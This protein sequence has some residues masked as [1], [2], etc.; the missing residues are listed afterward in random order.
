MTVPDASIFSHE[1]RRASTL[2]DVLNRTLLALKK[3]ARGIPVD[4]D[5]ADQQQLPLIASAVLSSLVDHLAGPPTQVPHVEREAFQ[6]PVELIARLRA[7]RGGD[8]AYFVDDLRRASTAL[9]SGQVDD[10][11]L[12]TLEA[13]AAAA[14]VEASRV[15][16][17][18]IRS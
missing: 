10:A 12:Q 7:D 1:Y 16:R 14:D 13:V 2:S 4:V 15:F 9:A 17:R 8:L 6:L 3:Q 18:M 11:T 5:S